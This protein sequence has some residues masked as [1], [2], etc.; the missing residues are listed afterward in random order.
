ML[1][2]VHTRLAELGFMEKDGGG[3]VNYDSKNL[4]GEIPALSGVVGD[5]IGIYAKIIVEGVLHQNCSGYIDLG[6]C[7]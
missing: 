1:N 6:H 2:A 3:F 4:L 5:S 7:C